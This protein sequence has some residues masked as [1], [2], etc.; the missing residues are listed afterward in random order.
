MI[1]PVAFA[2]PDYRKKQGLYESF[3]F[4]GTHRDGTTA[5]WLKHN[6]LRY[7]GEKDVWVENALVLFDRAAAS[8]QVLYQKERVSPDVFQQLMRQAGN[9]EGFSFN[10][11]SGSFF[12]ISRNRLRGR[13]HTEEG[14]AAWDLQ[15]QRSDEVLY[16]LPSERLYHLPWPKK[17]V[18]TRDC[19]LGYEGALSLG[20]VKLDGAFLGMNGHNWGTEHAHEYAYANCMD[21]REG[22]DAFFDAFSVKLALAGGLIHSPFLSLASLRVG[23]DWYHFNSMLRAPRQQVGGL[24]NYHWQVTLSN[25]T[26]RLEVDIDGANPRTE[27]W[28]ALHYHHPDKR[29]SVVKNT[30]FAALRLKLTELASGRQVVELVSDRC[31]LETL[32]PEN[33]PATD[34]Y[35]GVA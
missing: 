31:E 33:V 4:R 21:F 20:S 15:L 2:L 30:K 32:L 11:S 22:E 8:S 18:L 7:S 26:H 34:R 14:D 5:F 19:R 23:K 16:H 3:Y 13:M 12:E 10:F 27:P 24:S 9:W 6:L 17:K 29:V 1:D 28:V 35:E 25:E